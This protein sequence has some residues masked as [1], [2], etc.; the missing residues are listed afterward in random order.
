MTP[1]SRTQL[2]LAT[3][4]ATLALGAAVVPGVI[5]LLGHEQ[6]TAPVSTP[7]TAPTPVPAPV[8]APEQG[9]ARDPSASSPPA[10]R[11]SG[12]REPENR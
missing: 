9:S 2:W 10:P 11:R 12:D 1:Q 4:G 3:G 6:P 8:A 5:Q 7:V